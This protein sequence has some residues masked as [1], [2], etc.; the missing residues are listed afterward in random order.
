MGGSAPDILLLWVGLGLLQGVWRFLRRLKRNG[1][2][3]RQTLSQHTVG[4]G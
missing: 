2:R 3:V 1:Q 4:R